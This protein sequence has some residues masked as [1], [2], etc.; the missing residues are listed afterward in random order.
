MVCD[1]SYLRANSMM[2]ATEL[3]QCSEVMQEILAFRCPE[4]G[5]IVLEGLVP[6]YPGVVQEYSVLSAKGCKVYRCTK[7]GQ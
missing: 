2:P 1:I 6:R 3:S 7:G 5:R 4:L